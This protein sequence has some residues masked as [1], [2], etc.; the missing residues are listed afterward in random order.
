M[1]ALK[2]PEPYLEPRMQKHLEQAAAQMQRPNSFLEGGVARGDGETG[3]VPSPDSPYA[4]LGEVDPVNLIS[5]AYQIATGMVSVQISKQINATSASY[6][7]SHTA[8]N[9]CRPRAWVRG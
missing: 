9:F 6:P 8:N 5:F 4:A 7:G 1:S 3:V 2:E